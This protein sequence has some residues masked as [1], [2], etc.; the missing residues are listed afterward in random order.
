MLAI[1][2]F[3]CS[4][5]VDRVAGLH[6][7]VSKPN[8]KGNYW[9]LSAGYFV[10]WLLIFYLHLSPYFSISISLFTLCFTLHLKPKTQERKGDK[11][12]TPQ[13]PAKKK[14]TL[15]LLNEALQISHNNAI[16]QFVVNSAMLTV[17]RCKSLFASALFK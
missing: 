11:R 15:A 10:F 6:V 5:L 8:S 2:L 4:V 3:H 16:G 13:R 1:I 12:K 7:C 9:L 17:Q 14:K